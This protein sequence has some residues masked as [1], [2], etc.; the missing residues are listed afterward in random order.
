[1]VD[2][3]SYSVY[4][5]RR[6]RLCKRTIRLDNPGLVT[7]VVEDLTSDTYNL[8]VSSFNYSGIESAL[9]GMREGAAAAAPSRS[10]SIAMQP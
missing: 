4:V 1:M 2:L 3:A 6:F 9:Y 7:C 5:G 8:A 10:G